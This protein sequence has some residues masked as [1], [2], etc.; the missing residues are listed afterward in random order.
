MPLPTDLDRVVSFLDVLIQ[1][2]QDA[3]KYNEND[4]VAPAA[5]LWPDQT[6]Q[7]EPLLPVLR[8]RLP[9]LT[10]GDYCPEERTGPA[11]YLR[12]MIARTLEDQLPPDTIPVLY[13]P[14]YSRSDLRAVEECPRAIQPLAELQYR[15]VIFGHKNGKDW[16]VAGFLQAN[17]GGL[18]IPV[19]GDRATRA[20]LLR[21]LPKLI[22]EP[23]SHLRERAPLR[24]A[25]FDQLL[26]PDE[27]RGLLLWLNDPQ[28]YPEQIS[29]VEWQAFCALCA[30]KYDFRPEID[31]PIVA[32]EKLGTRYGPWAAVWD[33]YEEAPHAYPN[34]PNWLDKARPRQLSLLEDGP[35]WPAANEL[36]EERLRYDLAQL[37]NTVANQARQAVAVLEAEHGQRRD[38]AWAKIGLSPLAL[39]L[40]HLNRLAQATEKPLGGANLPALV[41]HYVTF[42]WQA[43]EAVLAALQQVT[44]DADVEVVRNVIVS[45]YRPWLEGAAK[46]FQQVIVNATNEVYKLSPLPEIEPG[47]CILFCDALRFDLGKRLQSILDKR[48][49]QTRMRWRLA[50]LP[51]VTPTAKPAVSPAANRITGQGN[52]DLTPVVRESGARVTAPILRKLLEDAAYQVLQNNELGSPA[53]RAWTEYGAID[54]YGHDHGSMIAH[55]VVKELEGLARRVQDLLS[56][57]WQRIRVVTDH[58]WLMLPK[59]LPK[60]ELSTSLTH[61]RKGRCA[62]LKQGAQSDYP[63]VAWHWDER[64]S[65]A[66]APGIRCY[67]MGK[68]YEHGGLSPQECITP[69]LDV[70]AENKGLL[71]Q[72]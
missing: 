32:A 54:V 1:A 28:G 47:T 64:V 39:A 48:N 56:H 16:T 25:F 22:H 71:D 21:A 7:W 24:A 5:I 55:H 58:G 72:F 41:E 31:G 50:A 52:V 36:A 46:V 33:R 15:G 18:G 17:D 61:L 34:L 49:L 70:W 53:G 26:H 3:G 51:P 40:E 44:S 45:L 14:G 4:T 37:D 66:M 67:E 2:I 13:L 11:Y 9:L 29:P 63:T 8:K 6:R 20:A 42:G 10:L 59:G 69:V 23:V 12:C 43:D 19:A 38:W 60:A 57:G 65:I 27:V 35:T 68:E 30:N 62:V